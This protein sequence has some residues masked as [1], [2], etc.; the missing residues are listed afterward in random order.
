[1]GGLLL[2]SPRKALTAMSIAKLIRCVAV[3][4]VVM[5]ASP[6]GIAAAIEAPV[7]PAG[8]PPADPEPDPGRP[9]H[10]V[11]DC[12]KTVLTN[13]ID[14]RELM[15]AWRLLDMPAAQRIS[16]GAG[17][18]VGVLDTGVGR[19]ARMPH[20]VAAGDYVMGKYGDGANDC[21]GHG[22]VVASLIGG[23]PAG[24]PLPSRPVG[25]EVA[26]RPPGA[27]APLPVPPPPPPPT[28]TVTATAPPPPPPP[29]PPAPPEDAPAWNTG[30]ERDGLGQR[31]LQDV[32]ET[33][34]PDAFVGGA[35]DAVVLTTRQS[36]RKFGPSDPKIEQDP[37]RTERAG[38]VHTLAEGIVH[39]AN[40][41]ARVI[42]IS[43]VSCQ[44]TANLVDDSEIGQA[45]R[46]AVEVKD[47]LIVSAA[48]NSG[49][50]GCTQNP[51]PV[52]A[53]TSD[54]L[55]RN[56]VQTIVTPGWYED[57]VL[58]VGATDSLGVPLRGQNASLHGPWVG[59]GAPGT[60]IQGLSTDGRLVN[61]SVDVRTNSVKAISGSSFASA[62][63]SAVAAQ[64]R[65][66][67]PALTA[68]QVKHRLQATAH[69][70]AGGRDTAIGF[71]VVDPV[72]ALTWAGP[73][74]DKFPPSLVTSGKLY[75]PPPP[76]AQDPRPGRTVGWGGTVLIVAV[77]AVALVV[78]VRRQRRRETGGAK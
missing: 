36:S 67:F 52:P 37:E 47:V 62:I 44:P 13:T 43:T 8:P 64:V 60:D 69:P 6:V 18:I 17:V 38:N 29:P 54:P 20:V 50:D 1:M 75:V 70:P 74:G 7:V 12:T 48:G 5:L 28:V 49:Q 63:V 40:L 77:W 68:N 31:W 78:V 30:T 23:A 55:G 61:A 45:V 42:N 26:P 21:D 9:M 32:P 72:A 15:P 34:A 24:A 25:V 14:P 41:G 10:Q 73:D 51:D 2:P 22:T 59:I 65:A 76:A 11:E 33:A 58:T 4:L 39:L 35:P 66:K 53:Y 19:S 57:Y 71:G 56:L 3:A 27:P 16:T 46:Y